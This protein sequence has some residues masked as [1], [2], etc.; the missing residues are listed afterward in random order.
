MTNCSAAKSKLRTK[1]LGAA[2]EQASEGTK[3]LGHNAGN[4]LMK[5]GEVAGAHHKTG[6]TKVTKQTTK[7]PFILYKL[8]TT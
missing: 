8:R 5:S 6:L 4:I 7:Q 1:T 2:I 3:N